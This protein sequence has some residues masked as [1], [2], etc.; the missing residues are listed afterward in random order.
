MD[1]EAFGWTSVSPGRT[2]DKSG[3]APPIIAAHDWG[4]MVSE[5]QKYIKSLNFNYRVS[6]RDANVKYA[7]AL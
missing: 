6:L 1:S 2:F 4:V 7:Y 3:G 5:I